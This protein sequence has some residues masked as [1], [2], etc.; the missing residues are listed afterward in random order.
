MNNDIHDLMYD[1]IDRINGVNPNYK[2]AKVRIE[3]NSNISKT[4]NG[5]IMS[6]VTV[7]ILARWCKNI[8]ISVPTETISIIRKYNRKTLLASMEEIIRDIQPKC[9]LSINE[10]AE[11]DQLILTIGIPGDSH[12]GL[13]INA[14]GWLAGYGAGIVNK[15]SLEPQDNILGSS[16]AACL[17]N[18][19]LFRRALGESKENFTRWFSLYSY[20]SDEKPENLPNPAFKD[21]EYDFGVIHQIGCG[22]IGSSFDFF[23]S[24][25]T[26]IIARLHLIDDDYIEHENLSSSLIFSFKDAKDKTKKVEACKRELIESNTSPEDFPIDYAEYIDKGHYRENAPDMILCF[27]NDKNIWS[28]IQHNCPPLTFHATTSKSWG[29]NFGRHIPH[30]EWCIMCRFHT[31]VK[32]TLV[33][34][35]AEG[36]ISSDPAKETL[37]MLPFLA[38]ASAI[39]TLAELYKLYITPQ[40]INEPS[41]VQ[42]SMRRVSGNFVATSRPGKDCYVCQDQ[43]IDI[44]PDYVKNS[45]YWNLSI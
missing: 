40:Y 14:N 23:L 20:N 36:N 11:E 28:T 6:I 5:Q 33:P 8:S 39:I 2:A 21:A 35:C 22:A 43:S 34:V 32:N 18:S 37:G 38:P 10:P 3:I 29:T 7:N 27:A 1:R 9:N 44:Y 31:E 12:P 26:D 15:I 24:L 13:W 17:G 45:K 19:E 41:F 4:F 42:F 16:F 25:T 30:K